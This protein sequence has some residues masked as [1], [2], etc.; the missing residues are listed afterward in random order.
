M[1]YVSDVEGSLFRGTLE[2][3]LKVERTLPI[4]RGRGVAQDASQAAGVAVPSESDVRR[5]QAASSAYGRMVAPPRDRGPVYHAYQVMSQDVLTVRRDAPVDQ[6]WRALADRGFGQAPVLDDA[7]RLV[8][9]VTSSDL[10]RALN[11]EAGAPRDVLPH[12]ASD[13]MTSP[14]VSADPVSDVRRVARVMLQFSL[15][16]VP[17][18]NDEHALVGIVSRGDILRAIAVEPPLTLWA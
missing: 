11:V 10:L 7:D 14:I 3:L 17:V 4:R 16:A 2:E 9:L 1:F 18:T 8:G 6:V 13:V 12:A 15:P 5:Y